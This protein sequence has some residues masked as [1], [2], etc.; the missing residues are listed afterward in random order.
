VLAISESLSDDTGM[1]F[2]KGRL[3][4][5]RR[6]A[7]R[8]AVL[9]ERVSVTLHME[10]ADRERLGTIATARGVSVSDL[11]RQLIAAFLRRSHEERP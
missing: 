2:R 5:A 7:G 9:A 1:G 10:A 11:I 3:G 6:G 4:G 8:P